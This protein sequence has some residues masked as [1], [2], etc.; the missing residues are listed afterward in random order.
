[1]R[2]V[3][4]FTNHRAAT[5]G[6]NQ[7]FE[8]SIA[9]T[10]FYAIHENG[11][12]SE[13]YLYLLRRM[14]EEKIVDDIIIFIESSRG[15]GSTMYFNKI[16]CYVV[17][18][19][20]YAE[21][22]LEEGDIIFARGGFRSWFSFLTRRK[23]EGKWLIL[24]AANTGRAR[25][26]FWDIILDDLI[27]HHT[28]DRRRRFFYSVKKCLHFCHFSPHI[29]NHF[30]SNKLLPNARKKPVIRCYSSGCIIYFNRTN[31]NFS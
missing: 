8:P 7:P 1:M 2:L 18:E 21:R 28:W 4:L 6:S 5:E 12:S 23:E 9:A 10:N 17:P 15:T 19:I 24:Y 31:I 26:K 13:G 25:W 16:P 27:D 14:L 29:I 3:F 20:A 11:L 22:Y 30:F